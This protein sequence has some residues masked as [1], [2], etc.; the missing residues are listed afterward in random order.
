[1]SVV[2]PGVHPTGVHPRTRSRGAGP[3]F[4]IR[5]FYRTSQDSF[6]HG[7]GVPQS[8]ISHVESSEAATLR[9]QSLSREARYILMGLGMAIPEGERS[10]ELQWWLDMQAVEFEEWPLGTLRKP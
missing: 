6:G 10:P 8:T 9:L 2:K 4:E 1:M 5:Q 3:L 7:L